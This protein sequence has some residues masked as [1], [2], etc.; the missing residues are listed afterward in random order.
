M[1]TRP[2]DDELELGINLTVRSQFPLAAVLWSACERWGRAART[3]CMN[4]ELAVAYPPGAMRA[5]AV[6][7]W[8]HLGRTVMMTPNGHHRVS[9]IF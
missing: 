9:G 5:S 7:P 1:T 4:A 2:S 6:P 8:F 3:T